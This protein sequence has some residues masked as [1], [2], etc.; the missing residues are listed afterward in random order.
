[1]KWK[2]AGG[3]AVTGYEIAVADNEEF[4]NA[5]SVKVK[6]ISK[7]SKAVS[8]MIAGKTY[9]VRVRTFQ[10]EKRKTYYSEWSKAKQVAVK[11]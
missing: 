3:S 1:M 4:D 5:R 10:K 7:V 8:R 6:G 2:K 11:K 9:Y